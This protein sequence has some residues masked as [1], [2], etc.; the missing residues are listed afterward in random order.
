MRILML[1]WEYAPRITGGLGVAC[2]EMAEA[3][4]AAGHQVDFLLPT[5]TKEQVSDQVK[6]IDAS[7]LTPDLDFWKK[8]TSY[9]EQ[10]REVSIGT[11]LL[12]YIGYETFEIA[13]TKK[14]TVKKLETT[15]E[16]ELLKEIKLT[17]AYHG[18]LHSELLKYALLAV[19]VARELKP[20]VVH[21]HDW[22]TFKAGCMIRSLLQIPLCVHLHSTEHDRNGIHAQEDILREERKGIQAADH[23][24]CVSQKVRHTVSTAYQ[25]P[26]KKLTVIPNASSLKAVKISTNRKPKTI[27][28]AG[29]LT[30]QKSPSTFIDLARDLTSRGHDFQYLIMGDGH[31]RPELEAHVASSNFKD[32]VTFTGFLERTELLKR[33]GTV[34]LLIVPSTSEPFGLI[35]LEALLKNVPVAAARGVGIGEFI[36][37]LPQVERWDHYSYIRLAER[38]MI[39]EDF[40]ANTM[41][42]CQKEAS[43]LSWKNSVEQMTA[44]FDQLSS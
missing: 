28:F 25:T 35:I 31:L 13:R 27:A 38:L 14:K 40:R 30:H 19:Q 7:A 2:Q 36:P 26:T 12:P 34:D 15:E 9:I 37:S 17:G 8:E 24:F 43:Q 11:R 1:G 20:D 44:K 3:F 10:I 22:V 16:S 41:R 42:Y 32:R 39:D 21:A 23:V 29:R 33:L 5:K 18:D 6:L 4:A